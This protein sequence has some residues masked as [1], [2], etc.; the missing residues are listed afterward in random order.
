MPAL[1]SPE[2]TAL[3]AGTVSTRSCSREST[4]QEEPGWSPRWQ[5]PGRGGGAGG[6]RAPRRRATD[7]SIDAQGARLRR[8]LQRRGV[9]LASTQYKYSA[10]YV[11]RQ[12]YLSASVRNLAIRAV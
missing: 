7:C 8:R 3:S 9:P 12:Y 11:L 10:E 4:L 6:G 1:S 2:S 5:T